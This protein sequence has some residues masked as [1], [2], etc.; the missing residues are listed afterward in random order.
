MSL[1]AS[2]LIDTL[3]AIPAFVPAT[4]CTGYLV[5]WLSDFHAFR[6]R[7]LVERLFWSLPLSFA[8]T[9]ITAD[10]IGHFFSLSAVVMC[11][12]A[13]TFGSIWTLGYE[14]RLRRKAGA[15]W[16]I[17]FQPLGRT[18]LT[19]TVL[20]AL[21]AVSLLVD[22][23]R[24]LHLY[25]TLAIFDHATRVGWIES[26][27]RTGLPPANPLYMYGHP[28]PMRYYYF[29][30]AMCAAISR[31]THLSPRGVLNASCI[32]AGFALVAITGLYLKHYLIV[33]KRLRPQLLKAIGLLTVG[34]LG[35][36]IN[37]AD[38]L[39]LHASLPGYLEVWRNG[40]ITGWLD[41][42]LW[43]PH[44][45]AS[46]I[47]CMMGFLIAS[48]KAAPN[49]RQTS[50]AIVLIV[51]AFASSFGF[52]VYVAF[53]FFL[54]MLAWMIWQIAF[55]GSYR[56]A[57]LI[58]SG[59]IGAVI[60][61]IPFL[62]ELLHSDSN[63]KGGASIFSIAVR[64]TIPPASLLA[65]RLFHPLLTSHPVLATNL[66][67]SAL[68]IPGYLVELGFYS[69]VL[70]IFLIPGLR[71]APLTAAQRSLLFLSVVTLVIISFVRSGVIESNDFGWRA[72]LFLQFPLLLFASE[73]L[74]AWSVADSKSPAPFDTT[75]LPGTTPHLMRALASFALIFG[76]LTT[77]YQ[78]LMVRFTVPFREAQMRTTHDPRAGWLPHN[79]YISAL[80]YQ[81]LD[82]AIPE[83][84]VV[85]YNP[86]IVDLLWLNP[87]W[88][89][90]A[91]QSV[92]AYDRP[93]CGAEFGG[94]F[95][96]CAILPAAIDAL[97]NNATAEQARAT[98][99]QFGIQ[100]LITKIYDPVWKDKN[101]WVWNLQPVVADPDFR[102][103]DC[104]H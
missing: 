5:A 98:C 37:L 90:V 73:L 74:T 28:A 91:H 15:K 60:V 59:G 81:E 49:A 72:A 63:V 70:L 3:L 23:Q 93:P 71:K 95:A 45:V 20:W 16:K 40:Q 19:L 86:R 7:S 41:S 4:V 10:L 97:Y 38:F 43:V 87:D 52:S 1:T 44:H 46:M 104:V 27:L 56:P 102:A 57:L 96:G 66:A 58:A 53:A 33:G 22:I 67:N 51:L 14:I 79:A 101:S 89:G 8:V 99:R 103:L 65:T 54:L 26:I 80:G 68:L 42:F 39:Y 75:G 2:Q 55:E 88:L 35:I 69:L 47:C 13:S 61:L 9:T 76:L 31:M 11:L 32:W 34:G 77:V 25:Q 30:Y 82:A 36:C 21:L 92:L 17:G 62:A 83:D 78:A 64:E 94:N 29:W 18:A 100:Y 12:L 85:Q 24:G 6:T 48:L 50:I 84:A